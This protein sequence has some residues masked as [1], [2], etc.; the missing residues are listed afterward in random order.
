M[1]HLR[2]NF[3]S[4]NKKLIIDIVLDIIEG[5][6]RAQKV[7]DDMKKKKLDINKKSRQEDHLL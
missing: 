1:E 7:D 3:G 5:E 6:K 4:T 2:C